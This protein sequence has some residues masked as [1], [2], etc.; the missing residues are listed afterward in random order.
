MSRIGRMPVEIP[1]GVQVEIDGNR[2]QVKG[3]K[4]ELERTFPAGTDDRQ[5][6][7]GT[8]LVSPAVG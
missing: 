7:Q 4:G 1:S 5:R 6:R 8:L 2:V 3:P